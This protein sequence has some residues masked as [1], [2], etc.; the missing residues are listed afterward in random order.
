MWIQEQPMNKCT[1]II[2]YCRRGV[3]TA[4]CPWMILARFAWCCVPCL[5]PSGFVSAPLLLIS[6]LSSC[7]FCFCRI[8]PLYPHSESS[9]EDATGQMVHAVWWRWETEVDWGSACC[10]N[11]QGCQTH[12]L[13]GG[14]GSIIVC[15]MYACMATMSL[16]FFLFILQ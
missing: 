4:Q 12:Q 1:W 11:C 5:H 2:L 10:G 8:D 6:L 9:R 16:F 14:M 15:F 7:F 3:V 13:C